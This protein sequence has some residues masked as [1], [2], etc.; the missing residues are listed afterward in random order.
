[1]RL[2][3]RWSFSL[4]PIGSGATVVTETYDCSRAPDWLQKAVKGGT[5]W[6]ASMEASLENIYRICST[7]IA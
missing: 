4:E 3:H 7:D 5:R 6:Q 2:G 1:M